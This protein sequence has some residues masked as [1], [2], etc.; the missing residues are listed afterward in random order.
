LIINRTSFVK[1]GSSAKEFHFF[2]LERWAVVDDDDDDVAIFGSS[3]TIL[4][5]LQSP[6][7]DELALESFCNNNTHTIKY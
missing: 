4:L 2:G 6:V 7:S 1:F 5:K 3:D